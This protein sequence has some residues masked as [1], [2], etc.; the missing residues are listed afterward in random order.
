M[1]VQPK[2]GLSHWGEKVETNQRGAHTYLWSHLTYGE[3]YALLEEMKGGRPTKENGYDRSCWYY[4]VGGCNFQG[5]YS[6]RL[7]SASVDAASLKSR[8]SLVNGARVRLEA[9]LQRDPKANEEPWKRGPDHNVKLPDYREAAG[10][11]PLSVSTKIRYEDDESGEE[12]VAQVEHIIALYTYYKY[13]LS[14]GAC[15][16]E[17]RILDVMP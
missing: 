2:T 17:K 10:Y 7:E 4:H 14:D 8:K 13:R 15:I 9:K 11:P 16:S 12:R 5:V 6:L 3:F 1:S